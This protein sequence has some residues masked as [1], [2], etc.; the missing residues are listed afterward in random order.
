MST[1]DTK[2]LGIL[3]ETYWSN[4]GWKREIKVSP[5]NFD[6]ALNAGY[7]FQPIMLSHDDVVNWLKSSFKAVSLEDI[8]TAFLVSLRTRQLELRSALGSFAI[9]KN[10]PDHVYQGESYCCTICGAFKNPHQPYDLSRLNFER[11]KWG[12]VRHENPEYIAFDLEQFAKLDKVELT[13][14]DFD[15]MRQIIEIARHCEPNAKPRDLEKG[16]GNVLK[17]NKAERETLIQ[18][19]AYCGIL[20]PNKHPDYFQSFTNYFERVVPPVKKMD[21]TYPICWWRG[22]DGVNQ[23]ALKYYFPQLQ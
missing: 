4:V 13:E 19:L 2:A 3:F 21:W 16:L 17:A 23:V 10:F 18:M 1:P 7:M 5:E 6:Y 12:G 11:Y 15:I 22:T 8:I 20:Q 9:A 14:Q